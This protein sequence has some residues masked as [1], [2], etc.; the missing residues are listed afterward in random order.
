MKSVLLVIFIAPENVMEEDRSSMFVS[1][2]A[3]STASTTEI[4]IALQ[5]VVYKAHI[6]NVFPLSGHF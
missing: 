6:Y 4:R 2:L 3:M 5:L 1:T